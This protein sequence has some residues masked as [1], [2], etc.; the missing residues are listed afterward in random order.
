MMNILLTLLAHP[1][2]PLLGRIF[3]FTSASTLLEWEDLNQPL[4][5]KMATVA[6]GTFQHSLQVA[7]LAEAAG[8][9][10]QADHALL[11]VAA[12]YH[13]IG[14]I[15]NPS[16]FIENQNSVNPHNELSAEESAKI[17]I[18]HVEEGLKLAKKISPAQIDYPFHR[19]ASRNYSNRIFLEKTNRATSKTKKWIKWLFSTM[20]PFPTPEKKLFYAGRL[21][22]SS[23]QKPPS[24]NRP[25]NG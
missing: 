24:T 14:K 5:K 16:Y 6:P 9:A 4:L 25:R 1:L 7:N 23:Q 21:H 22:R 13:D 15:S 20:D 8:R 12:L 11:K 10:V 2:I 19:Y 3:G 17:I 18:D